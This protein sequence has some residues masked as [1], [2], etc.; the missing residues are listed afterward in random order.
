MGT[1][2]RRIGI[3]TLLVGLALAAHAG[4]LVYAAK[5]LAIRGYDPVAYFTDA[6]ARQG[7]AEFAFEWSGATWH[8]TSAEHRDLFAAQPTKYAPQFGGHCAWAVSND[9]LYESDP[10]VWAIHE[11]KLYL[12]YN[13][14]VQ[15][16]WSADRGAAIVRGEKN[17]PRLSTAEK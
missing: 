13:R 9:Y 12:N 3:A 14:D 7:A 10:T 11:G 1:F 15:K 16:K 5:G 2:T 6:A 8:F 17:W 4:S